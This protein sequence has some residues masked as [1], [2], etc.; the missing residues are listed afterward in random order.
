MYK[1]KTLRITSMDLSRDHAKGIKPLSI[2]GFE[3]SANLLA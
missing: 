2:T 3:K 1:A